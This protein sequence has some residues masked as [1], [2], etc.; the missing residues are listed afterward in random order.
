MMLSDQIFKA[1]ILIIDDQKLHAF[2]L[3]KVLKTEGYQIIRCLTEPKQSLD[4]F[5]EYHPDII[6]LNLSI[7]HVDAFSIIETFG[8]EKKV[9]Y[10]PILTYSE[11]SN[12]EVRMRALKSGATDFLLKPYESIEVL[13]RIH[14]MIE[15]RI[16]HI[17]VK[18]QNKLL[19]S[20]VKERT[21]ELND[22]RLDIIRRLAQAA[23]CRDDDTGLHIYRMSQYCEKMA[24]KLGWNE[25]QCELMLNASPLHDIGK[26]GIPDSILLKPNKLTT[27][28]FEVM[29]TH[30]TIGAKLL[31]GS[32]SA[33]MQM[34]ETIALTHHEKWDGTGYPHQ[35]KGREIPMVGQI[36][37]ICD[38]FD[39]LTSKRPYKRAWTTEESLA[40]I[41]NQ[42]DKQF[43]TEL[44]EVFKKIVPELNNIK[45]KYTD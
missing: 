24:R 31:S 41:E 33:I 25:Q 44:V 32:S 26:I 40:E 37:S 16:L 38:V 34:A 13:M 35:L 23:E 2:F 12:P 20:K 10:L 45:V 21:Q 17:Q 9:D 6:L 1:K 36:C 19:E 11:D 43:N 3:E 22:T 42:K 15:S 5:W 7:P 27:E 39:A 28:E 8:T 29:K 30:T 18:D 14:N 4:V